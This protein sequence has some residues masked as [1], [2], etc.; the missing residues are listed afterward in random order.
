MKKV[1]KKSE[2]ENMVNNYSGCFPVMVTTDGYDLD[3]EFIHNHHEFRF[4]GEPLFKCHTK[5]DLYR[6]WSDIDTA[7]R[8]V[9]KGYKRETLEQALRFLERGYK[10]SELEKA[11]EQRRLDDAE[12]HRLLGK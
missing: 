6:P 5:D 4:D 8:L 10:V 11:F 1:I 2:Y 3:I 7:R 12:I 9:K